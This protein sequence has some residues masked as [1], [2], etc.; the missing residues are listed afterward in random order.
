MYYDWQAMQAYAAQYGYPWYGPEA[1]GM[2]YEEGGWP[3]DM[4]YGDPQAWGGYPPY[5]PPQRGFPPGMRGGMRGRGRGG[6]PGWGMGMHNDEV[7]SDDFSSSTLSPSPSPERGEKEERQEPMG[8]GQSSSLVS[9]TK[10][11]KGEGD[12]NDGS[13]SR[14]QSKERVE[15]EPSEK[16]SKSKKKHKKG[17]SGAAG[18]SKTKSKSSGDADKGEHEGNEDSNN[19]KKSKKKK[20]KHHHHSKK[21]KK[22]EDDGGDNK[23]G[24]ISLG[25]N[26]NKDWE[27]SVDDG[28]NKRDNMKSL[29][30]DEDKEKPV[31]DGGDEE[32]RDNAENTNTNEAVDDEKINENS[33]DIVNRVTFQNDGTKMAENDDEHVKTMALNETASTTEQ[34]H[35]SEPENLNK[36]KKKVVK[37]KMKDASLS[38]DGIDGYDGKKK[39]KKKKMVKT[40]T[41]NEKSDCSEDPDKISSKVKKLKKAGAGV[42]KKTKKKTV[43]DK[44]GAVKLTDNGYSEKSVLD[45]GNTSAS[46]SQNLSSLTVEEKERSETRTEGSISKLQGGNKD[47]NRQDSANEDE[48][49]TRMSIESKHVAHSPGHK[50]VTDPENSINNRPKET[51]VLEGKSGKFQDNFTLVRAVTS[52]KIETDDGVD[53]DG[54]KQDMNYDKTSEYSR[55]EIENPRKDKS[56]SDNIECN[57]MSRQDV[58]HKKG[59][60]KHRDRDK[61]VDNKNVDRKDNDGD[62]RYKKEHVE[63]DLKSKSRSSS[64][65][66]GKGMKPSHDS[67]SN[68]GG[69]VMSDS[70]RSI[71]SSGDRKIKRK[72][73]ATELDENESIKDRP[74]GTVE[75]RKKSKPI[76]DDLKNRRK[77]PSVES[78]SDSSISKRSSNYLP[79]RSRKSRYDDDATRYDDDISERNASERKKY[80]DAR[81]AKRR[82]EISPSISS[83]E[84]EKRRDDSP[85]YYHR[86]KLKPR[87]DAVRPSISSLRDE[88]IKR[89]RSEYNETQYRY[90]ERYHYANYYDK[91]SNSPYKSG[92]SRNNDKFDSRDMDRDEWRTNYKGRDEKQQVKSVKDDKGTVYFDARQKIREMKRKRE[93][94]KK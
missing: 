38:K 26:E 6:G 30:G 23:A 60:T 14:S 91:K 24:E 59:R 64:D 44:V 39:K 7:Y 93:Q 86:E 57:T 73:R 89:R 50:R 27:K 79:T 46:S 67:L 48:T 49:N 80:K 31:V 47:I 58:R 36:A 12:R 68:R 74:L 34:K 55:N 18:K 90:S 51:K 54:L 25:V 19:G 81:D 76:D 17:S 42:K 61:E 78:D 72:K 41:A 56:Q 1:Y 88:A 63:N 9:K 5:F 40:T 94:E 3:M 21:A 84:K 20:K 13:R 77:S 82:S 11:S 83:E 92:G 8:D 43:D 15:S 65:V 28:E 35:S 85:P 33:N 62:D 75:N 29:D 22:G 70:V 69:D 87:E 32:A 52:R 16:K 37:K 2:Y 45:E 66:E 10:L 71:D 4:Y 53:Q